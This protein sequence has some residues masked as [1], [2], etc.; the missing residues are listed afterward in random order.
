MPL[1]DW[2][3]KTLQAQIR[4]IIPPT[5]IQETLNTLALLLP[6][7]DKHIET[8]FENEKIKALDRGSFP[9]IH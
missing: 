4:P 1:L 2:Q 7:H 8:W 5:L 6:E 3:V 9:L